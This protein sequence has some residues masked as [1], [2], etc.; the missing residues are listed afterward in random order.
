MNGNHTVNKVTE[1]YRLS[2]FKTGINGHE[3]P[4]QP[5]YIYEA[6]DVNTPVCT[7]AALSTYVKK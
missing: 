4:V 6:Q 3:H 1:T 2:N 5:I 7:N